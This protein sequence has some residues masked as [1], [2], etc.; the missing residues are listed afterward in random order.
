MAGVRNCRIRHNF[1]SVKGVCPSH[2]RGR[3]A[4]SSDCA[5]QTA[6]LVFTP[7]P[8]PHSSPSSDGGVKYVRRTCDGR[9]N[10]VQQTKPLRMRSA[11]AAAD[12]AFVPGSSKSSY[13]VRECRSHVMPQQLDV[14][15]AKSMLRSLRGSAARE[16][17]IRSSN[18]ML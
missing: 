17:A 10:D 4:T 9:A 8:G 12:G 1:L 18:S 5:E 11:T 2:V 13:A 16:S 14:A 3:S 15:G 7:R 6:Q